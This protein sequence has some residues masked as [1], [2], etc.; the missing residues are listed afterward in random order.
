MN[1]R[2]SKQQYDAM[3]ASAS[4]PC[5]AAVF[6]SLPAQGGILTP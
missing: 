1:M 5:A 3:D 2:P 6:K 4:T